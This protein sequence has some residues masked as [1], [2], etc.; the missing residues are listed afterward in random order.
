MTAIDTVLQE[1]RTTAVHRISKYDC[2]NWHIMPQTHDG[3]DC[4]FD[5]ADYYRLRGDPPVAKFGDPWPLA[6]IEGLRALALCLKALNDLAF[7]EITEHV[8]EIP[9]MATDTQE[10]SDRLLRRLT[11]PLKGISKGLTDLG[12]HLEKSTSRHGTLMLHQD[13]ANHREIIHIKDIER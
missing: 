3:F 6:H 8:G 12:H 10:L 1:L 2:C 11:P 9:I 5:A 13:A 4:D 7:I